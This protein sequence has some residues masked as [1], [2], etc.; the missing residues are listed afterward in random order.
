MSSLRTSI[1]R[2]YNPLLMGFAGIA[3]SLIEGRIAAMYN[4][5]RADLE[6]EKARTANDVQSEE[7]L[8]EAINQA[9]KNDQE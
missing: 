5:Y 1:A 4:E 7:Q 6:R 2:E 3:F 8:I 9:S